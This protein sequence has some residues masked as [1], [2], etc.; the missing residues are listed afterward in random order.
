MFYKVALLPLTL[1]ALMLSGCNNSQTTTAPTDEPASN[2]AT[3]EGQEIKIATESTYKP[4]S[5][6]DADGK[7]IGYEIDLANALCD[8]MKAKC[9]II[10]QDWDGLI[11]GLKA[12]K[13]DAIM[14]GMSITPERQ[15]VVDFTDPYFN[16]S[17]VF[18]AKKGDNLSI[19]D[20]KTTKGIP[21]AAQR[22][23]ISSQYLEDNYPDADVKLYDTQENA[24]LD[25]SSGRVR[26]ILSD[27]VIGR[28][29]LQTEQGQGFEV[30]G[31][32]LLEGEDTMGIALR[33]GDPL[34]AKFNTA[35]AAIKANGQYDQ[36]TA[37][38]FGTP[39]TAAATQ[40]DTSTT[41]APSSAEATVVTET[42]NDSDSDNDSDKK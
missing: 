26:G 1:A 28:D 35:L 29:W 17:L 23:T 27:K 7:L 8:Q 10:S 6:T 4:F 32:E 12:K 3:A 31:P 25:L 39:T 21:V 20:L 11:P 24:Y 16:N 42:D 40:A 2:E 37:T 38:Y 36:I 15:Q 33:K 13:F 41:V 22:S 18:I 34:V 9:E 14:A 19:D 5:Y 30:K